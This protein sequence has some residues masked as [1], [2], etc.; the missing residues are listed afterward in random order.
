KDT[1]IV[2]LKE[3]IKSLRGN[4]EDSSVKMDMDEIDTHVGFSLDI[5]VGLLA[6]ICVVSFLTTGMANHCHWEL[7]TSDGWLLA[8][9]VL[10]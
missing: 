3:Q 5:N 7:I 8:L 4:G 2:K 9:A 10:A 1:V 6:L